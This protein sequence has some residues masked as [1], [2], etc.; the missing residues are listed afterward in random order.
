MNS[1]CKRLLLL[2][3]MLCLLLS[4]L[5]LYSC[6]GG[7]GIKWHYGEGMP[8][9]SLAANV[10]DFYLET[11]TCDVY[12]YTE[13][14]WALSF[15]M[16]GTDGKHGKNGKNGKNGEDGRT[17]LSGDKK[18]KDSDGNTG[19]RYLNTATLTVYEKR[20]GKWNFET[21]FG[22]VER[23]D[24]A[25]DEDGLKILCIG[26]S[27]SKD[28]MNFVPEILQDLGIRNFSVGHLYIAACSAMRHYAN[29]VEDPTIYPEKGVQNY[30]YKLHNGTKWVTKNEHP[31]KDAI[32][33]DNWDFIIIQ[34]KSS[35]VL[36]SEKDEI[37]YYK[38]L[39][40]EVKKYHPNATYVWNM[41][42]A[43][44][45]SYTNNKQMY[46]YNQIIEY[47]P[48]YYEMDGEV[49]FFIPVGTAIQ[50]ARSS[51][52]GDT[53]NRDGAHLSYGV[54]CYTASLTFVGSITG[55]DISKVEWRPTEDTSQSDPI[56]VDEQKIAIESAQNALKVPLAVTGSQYQTK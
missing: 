45:E 10:G 18:P 24:Y 25:N 38:K 41:T 40:L 31:I 12:S 49:S 27:Y 46:K 42:W 7:D 52:L 47:T 39:L 48:L 37:G 4:T 36:D 9:D 54:G 44:S 28:T 53:M 6:S 17:W 19:D 34:H 1:V 30:Q 29:L 32:Q 13:E 16:K 55:L 15:N 14:G 20:D 43:G 22:D 2:P 23:Y 35:D 51:Y 56:T 8:K 11:E 21:E 50:N 33:S 5:T 26:N 3:L